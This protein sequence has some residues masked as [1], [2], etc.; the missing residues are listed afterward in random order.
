MSQDL[1]SCYLRD[2]EQVPIMEEGGI[3]AYLRRE[4]LLDDVVGAGR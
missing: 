2:A 3:E 4:V 1:V